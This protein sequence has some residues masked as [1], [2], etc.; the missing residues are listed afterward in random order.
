MRIRI[1]HNTR[2]RYRRPVTL[3]LHRLM[4]IPRGDHELQLLASGVACSPRAEHTW[5][6]DIFGNLVATA[7]FSEPR[8]RA[9]DFQRYYRG[10]VCGRMAGVPDRATCAQLSLLL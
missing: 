8:P 5:S 2:Y 1:E 6:Q 7:K 9:A 3:L 4:L 10:T